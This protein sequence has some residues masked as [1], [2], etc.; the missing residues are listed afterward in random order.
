MKLNEAVA[1]RILEYCNNRNITVNK[2][3][4]FPESEVDYEGRLRK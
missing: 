2:L 4:Q 1:A 3:C